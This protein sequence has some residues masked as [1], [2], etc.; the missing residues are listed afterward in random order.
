[1]AV[2]NLGKNAVEALI[3]HK[4]ENPE[5]SLSPKA[6]G[7]SVVIV[8][9]DNGNGMPQEIAENLFVP[10]ATKKAGGTGLGLTITKKIIEVH[11]GQICC[12]TGENGTSFVIKI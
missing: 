6:D 4:V 10:F 3:E 12:E 11:G 5:V 9:G 7:E 8:I 2:F 1:M